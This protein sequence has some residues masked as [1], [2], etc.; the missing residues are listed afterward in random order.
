M[1]F[2][3]IVED[4]FSISGRGVVLMVQLDG[5]GF[6]P[7]RDHFVALDRLGADAPRPG[8]TFR[9][10]GTVGTVA[11]VGDKGVRVRGCLTGQP[12][13][14]VVGLLTDW[15]AIPDGVPRAVIASEEGP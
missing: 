4:A 11:A 6:G 13:T 14:P 3:G 2:S 1:A 8:E 10:A 9:C 5:V 15:T 7:H 12:C